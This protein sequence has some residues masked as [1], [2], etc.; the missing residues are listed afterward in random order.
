[1][2]FRNWDLTAPGNSP[3]LRHVEQNHKNEY[4]SSEAAVELG[5]ERHTIARWIKRLLLPG[6]RKVG[7]GP[8]S[9]YLIPGDSVRK[10]KRALQKEQ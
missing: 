7:S 9:P 4:T 1:M 3:I 2:G 8:N 6:A 10:R 5:V